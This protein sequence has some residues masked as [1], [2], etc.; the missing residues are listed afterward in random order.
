MNCNN[1]I[2]LIFKL[3]IQEK[4]G[5]EMNE[6]QDGGPKTFENPIEF[7]LQYHNSDHRLG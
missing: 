7:I 3:P 4:K 6:I 2:N 1:W 5:G